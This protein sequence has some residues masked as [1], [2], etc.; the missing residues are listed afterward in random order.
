MWLK[1]SIGK[2]NVTLRL[3]R[4]SSNVTRKYLPQHLEITAKAFEIMSSQWRKLQTDK[5]SYKDQFIEYE[6]ELKKEFC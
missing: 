6:N 4:N 5:R 1:V 2:S 3:N